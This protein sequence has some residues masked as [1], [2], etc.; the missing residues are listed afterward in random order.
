MTEFDYALL[1]IIGIST[2][3]SLTKGLIKEAMSLATWIA[4]FFGARLLAPKA[5]PILAS[6]IVDPMYLKIASMALV[7]IAILILGS[8]VRWAMAALVKATGLTWTDRLLGMVFGAARGA[9]L[10]TVVVALVN[11]SPF[12]TDAWFAESQ[13]V[14][15]FIEVAEWSVATLW[16]GSPLK[17]L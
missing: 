8:V 7:F 14:P 13:V 17:E 16:E 3:M 4:A 9:L 6:A 1:A 15:K 10:V 11:L 12:R 2:L 5:E